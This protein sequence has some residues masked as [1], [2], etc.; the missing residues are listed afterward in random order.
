MTFPFHLWRSTRICEPFF[1]FEMVK[2]LFNLYDTHRIITISLMNLSNSLHLDI[3][4][5]VQYN[6]SS[7]SIILGKI[8]I[9]L[10]LSIFPHSLT[11][12]LPATDT[13]VILSL[14]HWKSLHIF[15]LTIQVRCFSKKHCTIYCLTYIHL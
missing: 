15:Y 2:S 8:K 4:K 3:A 13:S 7:C 6:C 9:L 12:W 1:I 10:P 14:C 5:S 11:D